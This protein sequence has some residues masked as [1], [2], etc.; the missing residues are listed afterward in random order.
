MVGAACTQ[1]YCRV[2]QVA[3]DGFSFVRCFFHLVEEVAIS[4]AR[5]TQES[6]LLR[7]IAW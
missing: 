5:I 6:D 2:A 3:K 7:R 1:S 4:G